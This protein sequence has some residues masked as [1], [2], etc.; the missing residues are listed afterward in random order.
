MNEKEISAVLHR[1]FTGGELEWK[2]QT[3]GNTNGRIWARIVPYVTARGISDRLN[4]AFG[5]FGYSISTEPIQLGQHAGLKC[6]IYAVMEIEPRRGKKDTEG[7]TE[8][9]FHRVYREDVCEITDIEAMKGAASGA[10][11]RAAVL[12]GIGR[13][14][15][16]APEFYA[17]IADGCPNRG[18]F[19]DKTTNQYVS[20]KW[21]LPNEVHQWIATTLGQPMPELKPHP[22]QQPVEK[23]RGAPAR[24]R[25]TTPVATT[26]KRVVSGVTKTVAG[27]IPASCP[28][29]GGGVWDNTDPSKKKTPKAPDWRCKDP[30]CK[31]DGKFVTAG[32]VTDL[33]ARTDA[34]ERDD[35]FDSPPSALGKDWDEVP[36]DET[37][38]EV[39]F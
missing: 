15:Y 4:E 12:F 19:K 24:E 6:Q 38:S 25:T 9:V 2:I 20:F 1:P 16:D 34:A 30:Q 14:L 28:V 11:K 33:P 31:Q 37:Q 29:C 22:L 17:L 23:F 21:D 39:P 8:L 10:L 5:P 7:N 13:Y 36:L 3:A 18:S 35:S 32:W 27:N 26:V